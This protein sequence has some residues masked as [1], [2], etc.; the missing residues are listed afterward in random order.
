MTE[1]RDERFGFSFDR[2]VHASLMVAAAL[3]IF[4]MLALT[5]DVLM[6][7]LFSVTWTGLPEITEYSLLWM[8]FLGTTWVMRIN[9]HIRVELLIRR[10]APQRRAIL[11]V[12]GFIM[13]VLTLGVIAWYGGALVVGDFLTGKV[14]ASILRPPAWTV[15]L[16]IPAG[17]VMLLWQVFLSSPLRLRRPTRRA[18]EHTGESTSSH[19]GSRA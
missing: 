3:V 1:S 5:V 16:V 11:D 13:T 19:R 18:S 15:E 10:L 14:V 12:V 2:I 6:R 17:L 9:R 8:T 4:D 7:F